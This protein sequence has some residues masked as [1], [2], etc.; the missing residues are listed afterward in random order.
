MVEGGKGGE[1]R[2][3]GKRETKIERETK[4][5]RLKT[6]GRH[7]TLLLDGTNQTIS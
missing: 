2:R 3:A 5:Q 4:R 7:S 6:K 1:G